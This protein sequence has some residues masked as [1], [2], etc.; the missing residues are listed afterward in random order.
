M[1]RERDEAIEAVVQLCLDLGHAESAGEP[2]LRSAALKRCAA[3]LL[4]LAEA[5]DDDPVLARC[6]ELSDLLA[7]AL[8]TGGVSIAHAPDCPADEDSSFCICG[9]RSWL[10]EAMSAVPDPRLGDTR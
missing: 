4:A 8:Y 2:V 7:G 6:V 9:Y 3:K 10:L 1:T 5:D